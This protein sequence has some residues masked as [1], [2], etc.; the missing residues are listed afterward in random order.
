MNLRG[1]LTTDAEG[2]MWFR[3]VKPAGYPIPTD[4][5]RRR[6]AQALLVQLPENRFKRALAA[7]G[8]D[9]G[10]LARGSERLAAQY[11]DEPQGQE[12]SR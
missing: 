5:E 1:K 10:L 4:E 12:Q 11:R 2:R 3:S 6:G 7:V 8:V 9:V